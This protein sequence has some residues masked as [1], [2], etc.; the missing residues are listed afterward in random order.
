MWV[1]SVFVRSMAC[2]CTTCFYVFV[3]LFDRTVCVGCLKVCVCGVCV[4]LCV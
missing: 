2:V 3:S 1:L 4:C